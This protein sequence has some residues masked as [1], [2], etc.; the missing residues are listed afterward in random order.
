MNIDETKASEYVDDMCGYLNSVFQIDNCM[1]IIEDFGSASGSKLNKEKSI[2]MVVNKRHVDV[3]VG[4]KLTLGPEIALGVPVGKNISTDQYWEGKIDKMKNKIGPWKLRNLSF[5]GKV[6]IINSLGISNLLYG[7]EMTCINSKYVDMVNDIIW[8]FIWEKKK[9]FVTKEI[10]MLPRLSGGINLP[11]FQTIVKVKR[12]KMLVNMLKSE[13]KE[14]WGK[15]GIEYFK[16]LDSLYKIDMFALRVDDS[17]D[18]IMNSQIPQFYKECLLYFQ[19]FCRCGRVKKDCE[20]EIIWCNKSLT[21]LNSPLSYKHWSKNG[22]QF[23]SDLIANSSIR[24]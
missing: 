1:N 12:I 17:Y 13:G 24:D 16:C 5:R 6:H 7:S 11:D 20:N 21:F 22:I 4:F 23:I 18:D 15:I 8:D 2:G 10:C 3:N 14:T 19:E 9:V